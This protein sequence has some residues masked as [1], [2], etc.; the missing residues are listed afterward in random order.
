MTEACDARIPGAPQTPRHVL[1]CCHC[2]VSQTSE[3][4]L[5]VSSKLRASHVPTGRRRR[6][7]VGAAK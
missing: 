1:D 6:D 7:W 4:T 2:R 5:T 3:L